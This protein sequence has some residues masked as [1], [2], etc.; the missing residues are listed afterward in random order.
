MNRRDFL[1]ALGTGSS[2]SALSAC[3]IDDNRYYTPVE[4]V[5]PYLVRPEQTTPGTPTFFA[6][7]V[8]TGPDAYPSTTVHRE[9]RVVNVGANKRAPAPPAVTAAALFE[10]QRHYCPDRFKAPAAGGAPVT[11]EAGL[12]Q[13]ADAVKAAGPK[14]VAYVGPYRG[15]T[16]A[17]LIEQL[18]GGN[19]VFWEPGGRE[20][21]ARAVE[22]LFGVRALPRYELESAQY[23]LSFGADFLGG[24]FGGAWTQAGY[25]AA[26]D[27]NHDHHVARFAFVSPNRG[28]TGAVA[29][30]WHAV[31][32]GSEA[33]VALAL[34]KLV[35]DKKG[36]AGP[37][38]ALLAGADPAAAAAA[39]GIDAGVLD[40][41]A[42][43]LADSPSIALPG[44]MAGASTAAT[45]LAVATL[46]I[47]I[48]SGAAG[49]RVGIGGYPG[50]VHGFG[51]LEKLVADMNAGNV[52]V[53]LVDEINPVHALPALG[54]AAAVAKV[55]LAVAV[56]SHPS[57]TTAACGLV[58]PTSDA[59]ED[60][61]DEEPYKG[62]HLLRQP[63]Q[64]P[65]GDT[66]S[67][68]DVV[69]EAL[70]A[71]GASVP[72]TWREAL[73][74][75]WAT[76]LYPVQALW[77]G[78][79]GDPG[80]LPP[81]AAARWLA[82]LRGDPLAAALLPA[83]AEV[84]AEEAPAAPAEAEGAA[85]AMATPVWQQPAFQ[86]WWEH[87]LQ[88]GWFATPFAQRQVVPPL[89]GRGVPATDAAFE[90]AGSFYLHVFAHTFLGH[91]RYAN[92]PWAQEAPD[93]MTGHVWDSWA[94]LHP[95]AAAKL[96]VRDNDAITIKSPAGS[97]EVGV[98]ITPTIRPD[99]VGVAFG[100]GHTAAS[101]RYADGV[102]VNIASVLGAAKDSAGEA[103]AWQQAKVDLAK[104]GGKAEL[105]STFGGDDDR[106]RNFVA[107]VGAVAL[108]KHGDAESH[109][110]GEMTGI[111]H[112]PMDKRLV[113]KGITDFYGLPDHPTYR[114][115]LTVDTNACT[116]CGVCN[117]ACYAE[118][119]L[120][121]VGKVKVAEG[122]EMSW[123]RVNRYFRGDGESVHFVP[124]MCQQCGHA[125]CESVCPVLA[126]YHTSDGLNAM[127]YNRC[128][129]TRYCSNACPYGARKFNYHTYVWPEPFQL[130]LNPD[131]VTRNMGVMEKCTFCVQRIRR[132]KSAYRDQG[133]L[134]T[135]PDEALLQLPACAEACPSQALTF[136]NL[137]DEHS[138]V[139]KHRKSGRAY[140][141]IA[142]INTFP[143][144]N[145]LARASFHH[146]PAAGHGSAAAHEEGTPSHEPAS[147]HAGG[148]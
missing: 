113:E 9:G 80:P 90:G 62:M 127:I 131:V 6:T 42:G 73:Q 120:P 58:L 66:R 14:K 15:G 21:E 76:E 112:L 92:A 27:P 20:A 100:N 50:P 139:S 51:A 8:T 41:I 12:K 68:G 121:V 54:F 114:F 1:K 13:L 133:F 56:S 105:V 29:D 93:P 22:S 49:S 145:Y 124:M 128:V 2:L 97:V 18:T 31:T 141:P 108:A 59:F 77:D 147:D 37:A 104:T 125:P 17:K 24:T 40:T 28:Q 36:Y 25:A 84:E 143:A 106:H 7:S 4:Q 96:G 99:T 45:Q 48:V 146:D 126:T 19:A 75:R 39:A 142:E 140:T 3:G 109:H 144:V 119:N 32:P 30:D 87:R 135:V 95:E 26:R 91:G 38:K 137:V 118:N 5:L 34:A 83:G 63:S 111:H 64:N 129:G 103:L 148:H 122:R 72:A 70:R 69:L 16:L 130:Q 44:G 132:T 65:L 71:T 88:E 61:G 102:G 98:E 101:G 81:R 117:I 55:G 116:G 11:W 138:A 78:V 110:P 52:A 35:A 67:L 23:V 47:N 86:R 107:E 82:T 94:L 123:I 115:G 79:G 136:G 46:L 74:Q 33:K 10:L 134:E 53:L 85:E 89:T 43:H 57:E 60:W